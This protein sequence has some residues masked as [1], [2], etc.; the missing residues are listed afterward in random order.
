M[1]SSTLLIVGIIILMTLVCVSVMVKFRRSASYAGFSFS[2]V[3]QPKANSWAHPK[4]TKKTR[5]PR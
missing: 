3:K 5:S 1:E 4:Q 2:D